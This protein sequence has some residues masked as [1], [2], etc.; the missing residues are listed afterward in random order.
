L[1]EKL[2]RRLAQ[3]GEMAESGM[4]GAAVEAATAEYEQ[5]SSSMLR[6]IKFVRDL[7][8]EKPTEVDHDMARVGDLFCQLIIVLYREAKKKDTEVAQAIVNSFIEDFPNTENTCVFPQWESLAKASLAFKAAKNAE[9]VVVWQQST[10]LFQAYN[11]FLSAFLGFFIIGWRCAL[12]KDFSTNVLHNSY[13]SKLNEFDQLTGGEYGPFYL[14]LRLAKPNLRNAIA[15][16]NVWFDRD[17]NIVRFTHGRRRETTEEMP[18]VEFMGL[19]ALGSLIAQYY[20]AAITAI[21]ILED[22]KKSDIEQLP[23]HLIRV[24]IH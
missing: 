6:L 23:A 16:E 11:E 9:P 20:L 14:I 5:I 12:S 10:R 2:K 3:M 4:F 7:Y 8:Q 21:V 1:K 19:A 15:H 17:S 13:G 24:F 18:L 22:G